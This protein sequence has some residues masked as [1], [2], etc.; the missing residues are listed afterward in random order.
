MENIMSI[1]IGLAIFALTVYLDRRYPGG[2][3][4]GPPR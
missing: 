3:W 2:W 4:F 1:C